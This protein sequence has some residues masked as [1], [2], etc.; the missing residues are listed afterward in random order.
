MIARIMA[1]GQYRLTDEAY[2]RLQVIDD[3]LLAA[4]QSDDH[5][6]FHQLFREALAL[7]KAGERLDE[8]TLEPSDLVLP[9]ADTSMEDARRL[10]ETEP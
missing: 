3:H 9:P 4:L 10:L 1:D 2:D 6:A 8:T 7:V 5:G